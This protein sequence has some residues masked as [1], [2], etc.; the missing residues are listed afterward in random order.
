MK[1]SQINF[2]SIEKL[3]SIESE[4]IISEFQQ[5]VNRL[6]QSNTKK[7]AYQVFKLCQNYLQANNSN[8]KL[9]KIVYNQLAKAS[10]K[11]ILS[12]LNEKDSNLIKPFIDMCENIVIDDTEMYISFLNNK[13]CYLSKI[14]FHRQALEL[15]TLINEVN[16]VSSVLCLVRRKEDEDEDEDGF[17]L[18]RLSSLSNSSLQVSSFQN[19]VKNHEVSIKNAQEGL[20]L[21]Q[22]GLVFSS[23][24][25]FSSQVSQGEVKEEGINQDE[26]NLYSKII[27]SYYN[28][29]VQQE[30]LH[31]KNDSY[32]SYSKA[33]EYILMNKSTLSLNFDLKNKLK[34]IVDE[35]ENEG[36]LSFIDSLLPIKEIEFKTK[37]KTKTKPGKSNNQS[38]SPYLERIYH[39]DMKYNWNPYKKISLMKKFKERYKSYNVL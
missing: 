20:I 31:R 14:K 4:E 19:N 3:F 17:V 10:N 1:K 15:M 32:T 5:E 38:Q 35:Q 34:L 7:S 28:L 39:K 25:S 8:E 12:L 22:L 33:N 23:F 27:L 2:N 11:I 30:Y 37:T 9:L 18:K 16:V 26:N 24:S 21:S 13:C 36:K 29:A 6:Y